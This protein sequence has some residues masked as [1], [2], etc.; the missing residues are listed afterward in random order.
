MSSVS[1]GLSLR[2]FFDWSELTPERLL[3]L[4]SMK[5]IASLREVLT[6]SVPNAT[7]PVALKEVMAKMGELLNIS[8]PEIAGAAW[9]KYQVLRKYA[10]PKRY[11]P[12]ET[13]VAPLVTHT[14][15]S[16]HKPYVEVLVGDKPVG[17]VDF[18]INLELTLEGVLLS[19]RG[20]KVV[21]VRIGS[22]Q[23]KGSVSCEGV[24]ITKR[25]KK[26]WLLPGVISLKEGIPIGPAPRGASQPAIMQAQS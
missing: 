24:V 22:C 14:I 4:E 7:W 13:I 2:D 1:V 25:E 8:L 5:K 20:S 15:T 3:P 21:E 11:R 10:D 18:E 19:I 12:D 6:R 9:N 16:V 26:L 23:G 17:R